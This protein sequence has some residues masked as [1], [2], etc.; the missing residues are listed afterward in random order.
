MSLFPSSVTYLSCDSDRVD[1]GSGHG[2]ALRRRTV[3]AP[4]SGYL[5]VRPQGPSDNE[6]LQ[7]LR[8]VRILRG[9]RGRY[10]PRL[11]PSSSSNRGALPQRHCPAISGLPPYLATNCCKSAALV[12]QSR[13]CR[14]NTAFNSL[15]LVSSAAA[16]KPFSPSFDVSISSFRTELTLFDM[17][18]SWLRKTQRSTR[19]RGFLPVY[20]GAKTTYVRH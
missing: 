14:R 13:A 7:H 3:A 4:P 20:S 9:W 8:R 5:P 12:A 16:R 17:A 6:P 19:S 1:R 10:D 2:S 15:L 18:P 11:L